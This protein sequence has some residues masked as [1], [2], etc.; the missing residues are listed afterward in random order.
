M[1][2]K[3]EETK[4]KKGSNRKSPLAVH[5]CNKHNTNTISDDGS[6][7]EKCAWHKTGPFLLF[8]FYKFTLIFSLAFDERR[9]D[10]FV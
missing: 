4:K 8:Y 2:H 10:K 7:E 1:K 5:V 3:G 6:C 9:M